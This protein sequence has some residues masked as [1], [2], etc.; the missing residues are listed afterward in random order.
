MRRRR[1]REPRGWRVAPSQP[2]LW[3]LPRSQWASC[4]RAGRI[5]LPKRPAFRPAPPHGPPAAA[6]PLACRAP[7]E[8]GRRAAGTPELSPSGPAPPRAPRRPRPRFSATCGQRGGPQRPR[9]RAANFVPSS[10]GA[11]LAKFAR[12]SPLPTCAGDAPARAARA[13]GPRG[14]ARSPGRTGESPQSPP[15]AP[16]GGRA[17]P[18]PPRKG[19]GVSEPRGGGGAG[20]SPTCGG[21]GPRPA[22]REGSAR[23]LGARAPAGSGRQLME[24]FPGG[25]P[26]ER[27]APA[28]PGAAVVSRARTGVTWASER[29]A[30]T[31]P[32]INAFPPAG[33]EHLPTFPSARPARGARGAAAGTRGARGRAAAGAPRAGWARTPWLGRTPQTEQDG[34]DSAKCGRR[35]GAPQRPPGALPAPRRCRPRPPE[36]KEPYLETV[37]SPAAAPLPPSQPP[38]PS[39]LQGSSPG[40]PVKGRAAGGLRALGPGRPGSWLPGLPLLLAPPSGSPPSRRLSGQQA[41]REPAA[42]GLGQV[43]LGVSK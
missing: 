43:E 11:I 27:S 15:P 14:A 7:P 21:A 33:A 16:L 17:E 29:A 8:L 4:R 5:L 24:T 6:P 12:P 35:P 10:A 26:G 18:P 19:G 37:P 3:S 23:P 22:A 36:P 42:L 2:P 40:D 1:T 30:P 38:A 20:T 32:P 13:P 41:L 39:W 31:R 25:A 28:S 9:R 34:L